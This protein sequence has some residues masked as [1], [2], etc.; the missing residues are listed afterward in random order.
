M[1]TAFRAAVPALAMLS[2]VLSHGEVLAEEPPGAPWSGHLQALDAALDRRDIA[3]ATEA[4][5]HAHVAALKSRMW[6]GLADVGD[7]YIRLAAAGAFPGPAKP[8]ARYLYLEAL[9]WAKSQRSIEGAL[10]MAAAF[11]RLGDRGVVEQCV[12]VAEA[13]ARRARNA[14]ALHQVAEARDRLAQPPATSRMLSA[15]GD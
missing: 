14:S 3:A 12:R 11:D 13:A 4:W 5:H 2:C 1:P 7:A 6:K 10:R 15:L 9:V 8:M